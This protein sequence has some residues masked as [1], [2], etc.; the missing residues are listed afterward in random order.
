ME[1]VMLRDI[2]LSQHINN[3]VYITFMAKNVGCGKQKNG[4]DFIGFSAVDVSKVEEGCK[5]FEA[6]QDQIDN[7]KDG[8][9]FEAAVDVK[10]YD[11]AKNGYSC[12]IYNI[13]R[14]SVSPA[15]FIEWEEGYN[16]AIKD[17]QN[18]I[19]EIKD[20]TYNKIVYNL[21]SKYWSKFVY[22]TAATGHHHTKMSGLSVH[23]D[24]VTRIAYNL[25]CEVNKM[26]NKEF[27]DVN[28]IIAASLLH[29]I[30]KCEELNVDINSGNVEYSEDS[31]LLTHIVNG[32]D[33]ITEM[34]CELG[35]GYNTQ[36][37]NKGTEE[38]EKEAEKI[39]LL[40]HCIASHHGKLEYGSPIE[41]HIP[42]A[43]IVNK[44]D[45][46]SLTMYKFKSAYKEIE[47][48]NKG[49][50]FSKWTSAGISVTYKSK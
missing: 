23:T 48:N 38:I 36:A 46:I 6:T 11:K 16:E 47:E 43:F 37:N 19:G 33:S 18:W 27:V 40:K 31:A 29:D 13:C 8:M 34:A 9:V 49:K 5:I 14:S 35:I 45:E 25:A 15:L 17:I 20:E 50:V 44:A 7:I 41:P 26:Y 3:R 21:L 10:P 32:I 22:W 1:Y 12:V 30:G 4:K 24:E 42:E 28:L 39:K 2:D